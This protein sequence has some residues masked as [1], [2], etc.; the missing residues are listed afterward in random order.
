LRARPLPD[1]SRGVTAVRADR[2]YD[3]D[4]FAWTQLQA[5][6]LRRFGRTRPN[7][8]LDVRHLA[9]EI[10][11]LGKERRDSLRSWTAR[12]IEHLLLLQHSPAREPRRGW[13]DEVVNFR[14][15]VERRLTRSLRRDLERRRQL[16]YAE[17]RRSLQRK[18]KRY[19]EIERAARLPDCCPWTSEQIQGDFWPPEPD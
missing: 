5:R 13:I 10:A 19:G 2:L 7:M 8:A 1:Y 4:F 15:E 14:G 11:D 16:L 9:E 18:L 12:I 3:D 6:E 17:A